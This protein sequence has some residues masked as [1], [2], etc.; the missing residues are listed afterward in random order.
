MFK[1]NKKG[2][3]TTSWIYLT[4]YSSVSI[5]NFEHIIAG[6]DIVLVISSKWLLDNDVFEATGLKDIWEKENKR[7]SVIVCNKTFEEGS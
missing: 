6:W 2:T 7:I 3:R 4:P 1:V 5:V